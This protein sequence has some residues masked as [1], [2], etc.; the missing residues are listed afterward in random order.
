M[1]ISIS[2]LKSFEKDV[3]ILNIDLE[4]EKA[5]EKL[6]KAYKKGR[7]S[8]ERLAYSVKKILMAKYKVGLN[9]YQPVQVENLYNDLNS[10]EDDLLYEEAIENAITVV[11]N[12]FFLIL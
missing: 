4:I 12:D 9:R 6:T 7:I 11:K 10:R 1:Y 5:K 2:V 3:G 8:E